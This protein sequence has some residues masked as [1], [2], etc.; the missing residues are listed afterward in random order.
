MSEEPCFTHPM[1]HA[2]MQTYANS[3]KVLKENLTPP[4]ERESQDFT[5]VR[6]DKKHD[7]YN[8]S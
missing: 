5:P 1:R 6:R 3:A 2:Q 7:R 8:L 4:M